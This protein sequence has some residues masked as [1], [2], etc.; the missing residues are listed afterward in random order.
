MIV[1]VPVRDRWVVHLTSD[2]LESPIIKVGLSGNFPAY[3]Y[4]PS[5][6]NKQK[7]NLNNC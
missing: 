1:I 7:Q 4:D 6:L 5:V 3:P 2:I